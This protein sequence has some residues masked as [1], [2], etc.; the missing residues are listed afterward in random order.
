MDR[1]KLPLVGYVKW[2]LLRGRAPAE[3]KAALAADQR[4]PDITDVEWEEIY[5]AG[6]KNARFSRA[7]MMAAPTERLDDIWRKA[8]Q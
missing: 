4:Y 8:T 3:I 5:E 1:W 7:L 2:W 6:E